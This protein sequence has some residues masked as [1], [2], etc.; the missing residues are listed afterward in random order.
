MYISNTQQYVILV[1]VYAWLYVDAWSYVLVYFCVGIMYLNE[2]LWDHTTHSASCRFIWNSVAFCKH[3]EQRFHNKRVPSRC[4]YKPRLVHSWVMTIIWLLTKV[5]SDLRSPFMEAAMSLP[6]WN[7]NQWS[8]ALRLN[9]ERDTRQYQTSFTVLV[10][11]CSASLIFIP[12]TMLI[13]YN[14]WQSWSIY[15][16]V[17]IL[18]RNKGNRVETNRILNYLLFL[19]HLGWQSFP[20]ED[21]HTVASQWI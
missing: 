4:C 14:T 12:Q 9:V 1:S 11:I 8:L 3:L 16:H 6:V 20:R 13:L 21:W 15:L 5:V 18:V 10:T 17:L 7:T 2:I 19:K